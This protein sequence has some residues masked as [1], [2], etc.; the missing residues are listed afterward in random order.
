MQYKRFAIG[1]YN[2]HMI[3]TNKF[4]TIN[5][6][7]SFRKP[8]IKNEITSRN[9]LSDL[10]LH[11]SF[12]YPSKKLLIRQA[13][14]LYDLKLSNQNT[15]IGNYAFTAFEVTM[16][17]EK[18]TEKGMLEKGLDLLCEIV[19]NP[20]VS[21]GKFN[22]KAF[23]MVKN[24]IV[25][26]IKS[27]KDNMTKYSLIRM[28]E[29]M[30]ATSPISYRGYGYQEDL[31]NINEANLYDYYQKMIKSDLVDIFVLGN[32]DVNEM[33]KLIMSKIPINTIKR[34]RKQV[35]IKQQLIRKR[36]KKAKEEEQVSQSKLSI[37]C[38]FEKLTDFERK[39]VATLYS[40]I[41]GGPT[42]SRLFSVVREKHSLA[43]Y[44]NSQ[45]KLADN[46]L[47]IY[48]G[49]DKEKYDKT[50]KLIKGEMAKIK[51][52]NIKEEELG[53]AKKL[54]ISHIKAALDIPKAIIESYLAK[55]LLKTDD[56]A[57]RSKK[58]LTVTKNDIGQVAKKVKI[59]T[60]FLLEGGKTNEETNL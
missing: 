60:V 8:I 5:I 4:K 16:L 13:Q 32:I 25:A 10:L 19:F 35:I 40:V 56:F 42:S 51:K 38:K 6:S 33:K 18:Y 45:T 54:S 22:S 2:L 12:N 9:F 30:D 47:I 24:E 31:D 43:Y 17:D 27:V 29:E 37:G 55:E 21:D 58:I 50:V 15:R 48:A 57:E 26:E 53:R 39:Y 52:G 46:L 59:D 7:I 1:P 28:L 20:L 44:V 3:K 11:S 34:Q 14:Q 41:L 23:K 49:I 36:L